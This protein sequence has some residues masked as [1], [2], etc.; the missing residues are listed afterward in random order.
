MVLLFRKPAGARDR[1][2]VIR[3]LAAWT[4]EILKADDE[5][6]VSVLDID[7]C[8]DGCC[9]LETVILVTRADGPTESVKIS[10]ALESITYADIEVALAPD[11][12]CEAGP[13]P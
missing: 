11:S 2:E 13:R 9:D 7:C 10:K 12:D 3:E 8:E 1:T 6:G 5:V 4:R